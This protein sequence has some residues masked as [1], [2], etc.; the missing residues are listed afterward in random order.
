MMKRKLIARN[1]IKLTGVLRYARRN[2]LSLES[3]VRT[4]CIN[5][6]VRMFFR[7]QDRFHPELDLRRKIRHE[8]RFGAEPDLSRA[9]SWG[10]SGCFIV[11]CISSRGLVCKHILLSAEKISEMKSS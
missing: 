10:V 8:R 7:H 2:S 5:S 9:V 3:A 1:K 4:G 6:Q 11:P